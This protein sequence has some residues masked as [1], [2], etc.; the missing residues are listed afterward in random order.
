MESDRLISHLEKPEYKRRWI[1]ENWEERQ[2]SAL[3]CW[4]LDRVEGQE[5]W[6][7]RQ[8]RP[9]VRSVGQLA[10]SLARDSDFMS[11]LDLWSGHRDAD[12]V[13]AL[14]KLLESEAVPYLAAWRLKPSGLRKFEDWKVTWDLQRR[15]DD[16]E[17]VGSIPVPPK[18]RTAD[19]IKTSYWSHRGKLDVPKERFILYPEAGLSSDESMILGWAGWDHAEQFLALAS[20]M[21]RM[22]EDGAKDDLLIPILAGLNELAPWVKQW[23]SDIDPKYGFSLGDFSQEELEQRRATLGVSYDDLD[24]WR[25]PK[26]TSRRKANT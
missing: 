14:T 6:F 23:H 20:H 4:L 11:V 8:G 18:Y 9:S 21:D 1:E 22:I 17:T 25:P 16:G 10:D 5:Q 7:D 15:E 19:F 3:R 12:P 2:E 13:A 26:R 24:A